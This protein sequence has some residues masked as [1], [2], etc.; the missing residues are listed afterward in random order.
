MGKEPVNLRGKVTT[1]GLCTFTE[2]ETLPAISKAASIFSAVVIL[3]KLPTDPLDATEVF[4][5]DNFND[6]GELPFR[7][8]S[9]SLSFLPNPNILYSERRFQVML[10]CIH[11]H[12]E[13]CPS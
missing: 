10:A 13:W 5:G 2:T 12:V 9:L 1:E 3:T 8:S 6:T 4:E 7:R 11:Y